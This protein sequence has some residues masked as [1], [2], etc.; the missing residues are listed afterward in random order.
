MDRKEFARRRRQFMRM[1]GKD[2]I[3]IL[4]AAPVCHRNGDIE[5]AYRQ[6]SHFHYL[7]GFPEPDSVVVL[8]PGRPQAEYLLFVREH[9]AAREAWDGARSGTEGAVER[10]G[11]D[12]A[13]PI[14]DIDEILPGLLEQR[15]QIYY[16]MGTHPDF[17]S[18]VLS[19]VNGLRSQARQEAATPHEFVALRHVLDDMRL[20]KSR[21]E[22]ASL[23]RAAQIAV[24]A[25]RRA[26]RFARPGRMEYEVMAELLHEFRSHNADISYYPIVGGGANS[27][28]MH[29]RDN[30][31]RL[32]DGDLLLLDAGCEHELYASDITRTFPVSGRFTAAQRAVYEVVLEA[33]LSAID[34]VRPGNHWNHPHEAAVRVITQGLIKLGLLKGKLSVLLKDQAYLQFFGHRTG[35]WLGL[36]VHDVG[37]YK[38]GGEWRVLEPGMTLTV[39][40]GIY[41]RPSARVPK[42]FWN[43][44]VRIEDEVLVTADAP[45][46]LTGALE[47]TPEAI[48]TL[49]RAA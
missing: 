35:H 25:H 44:G 22:Q 20:Y 14:T 19:W 34:K 37:D 2:A 38:V 17:D 1:I 43:I 46:V 16:S 32:C 7:S 18:H 29:Y 12:D 36:D 10:Y 27:C 3:A 21:A 23:R 45:E 47:K 41:I 33:Q 28:V 30:N 11:A 9:D 49:L 24:G 13:F 15:S 5:Y 4:P 6:D 42:E 31:Q 8:V 39:E 26:M 48:E 40:P